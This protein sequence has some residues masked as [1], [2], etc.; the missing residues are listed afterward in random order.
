ML[1]VRCSSK[2]VI[3]IGVCALCCFSPFSSWSESSDESSDVDATFTVSEDGTV[4][5]GEEVVVTGN[6]GT[7]GSAYQI[8]IRV[9]D[10][11]LY[12]FPITGELLQH[13][14]SIGKRYVVKSKSDLS[15]RW[16]AP[17]TRGLDNAPYGY[18]HVA[19]PDH[20][21]AVSESGWISAIEELRN[22]VMLQQQLL[23]ARLTRLERLLEPR[24]ET[25]D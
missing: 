12:E 3:R 4:T 25:V 2:S 21:E 23:D 15:G 5:V 8:Y 19:Y 10:G 22:L 14:K 1:Q 11:S 13:D 17:D 9:P 6:S 16:L 7:T 20:L 24:S 18:M